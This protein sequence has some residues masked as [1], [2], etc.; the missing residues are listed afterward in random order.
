MEHCKQNLTTVL[1][2]Q[3]SQTYYY[4]M[5]KEIENLEFVQ[6]ANFDFIASLKN[7]GRK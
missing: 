5:Q 3:H 6:G 7:N 1:F 4:V 2:Y